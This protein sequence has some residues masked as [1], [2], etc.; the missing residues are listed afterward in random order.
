MQ[1]SYPT[2]WRKVFDREPDKQFDAQEIVND[3]VPNLAKRL[4]LG[5]AHQAQVKVCTRMHFE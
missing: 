4:G 3:K 2:S 1:G 5:M